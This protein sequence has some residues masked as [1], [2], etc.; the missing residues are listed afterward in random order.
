[1]RLIEEKKDIFIVDF[2]KYT[3]AH[4]ISQ[5]CKM[6]AGIAVPIKNKYKLHKLYKIVDTYPTCVF[7][8]YVFNGILVSILLPFF[9]IS[10]CVH[11]FRIIPYHMIPL[12]FRFF[13]KPMLSKT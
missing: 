3:I 9:K 4:C 12:L 1:M 6:G 10:T 7:H 8:N 5:D 13:F 11:G 2:D